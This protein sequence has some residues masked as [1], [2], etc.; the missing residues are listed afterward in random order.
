MPRAGPLRGSCRSRRRRAREAGCDRSGPDAAR[1]LGLVVEGEQSDDREGRD[2]PHRFHRD[3]ELVDVEERLDHEQVDAAPLEH[4]GL[5]GVERAV[6]GCVEHLEL[7]ERADCAGDEHL[8]PCDLARLAGQPDTR[9]VDRLELLLEV[10]RL[11]L[12]PVGAE[13]IRLDQ[14]GSGADIACVHG[15][16]ALRRAEIGFLRAAQSRD[17]AG[18]ERARAAVG[19]DRRPVTQSVE[20]AGHVVAPYAW[21]WCTASTLFPSG[22]STNAR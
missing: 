8:A 2:R 19:D 1:R 6:L 17:R 11:Q 22:S 12:A 13:S 16:D 10:M 3:D 7:A 18:D 14:L 21:L 20:E 15:D 9:R 4:L 5:L